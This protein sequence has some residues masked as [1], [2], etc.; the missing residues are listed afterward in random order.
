MA[1]E[2]DLREKELGELK[3]AAQAVVDMVD[4]PEESTHVDKTSLERLQGAPQKIMRYLSD[5]TR[6]YVSHVLGLVKYYWPKANLVPLGEGISI[7]CSEEKFT[8]LVEEVKP[9]ADRIVDTLEQ[10][11]SAES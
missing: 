2:K 8:A 10:E 3:A 11:P 9:I 5:I 7:D 6:G 4:P 1:E